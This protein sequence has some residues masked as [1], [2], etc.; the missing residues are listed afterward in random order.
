MREKSETKRWKLVWTCL[1]VCGCMTAFSCSDE[2]DSSPLEGD[3][4]LVEEE[5]GDISETEEEV[6]TETFSA[7]A[8]LIDPDCIRP[9]VAAHRGDHEIHPENS[10]AALRSAAG[11]GVDFVE[12][13]VRE[14]SDGELVLMHDSDVDRTTDG[15]G[16]VDEM[17]YSEIQALTLSYSDS[18]NPESYEIPT[19]SAA[20]ALAKELGLM[21]YVDQKTGRWDLV[22]E[23]IRSGPYYEQALVR[24]NYDIV[25]Q[26]AAEDSELLVMP[27]FSDPEE[28]A[29][30]AEAL[31]TL[32]IVELS[33]V[34]ADADF[35]ARAEELD[36]KVQQ[37]VMAGGD[38]LAMGGD[39]S[40]WKSFIDAGVLL[41]QTDMARL[42]VP[43]MEKYR[44]TGEFDETGPGL[45]LSETQEKRLVR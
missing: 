2:D 31:P 27:P 32:T 5:A 25:A 3:R 22:L 40:G 37:D 44:E 43:A 17:T 36:I 7:Y 41:L 21:L 11:V 34:G 24:D 28:M 42:L 6:E 35:C 19:F 30:A 23:A 18:E 13:D 1:L 38:I 39:Y 15:E 4:D 14:T 26:M 12:V 9:M 33:K 29:A 20:L 16:Y 45:S 10:L 8:C